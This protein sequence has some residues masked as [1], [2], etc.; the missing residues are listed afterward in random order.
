MNDY[1]EKLF[2]LEGKVAIVTGASRGIG[3]EIAHGLSS[4]GATVVGVA[5]SSQPQRKL[6][7][8]NYCQCDILDAEGF[9][10]ICKDTN[11]KFGKINILVNS[12]GISLPMTEKKNRGKLFN[13]ILDTNLSSIYR[14][15]DTTAEFMEL[16]GGG[17]IINIT[18]IGSYFGFPKNP[19]YV[20]SKGGVRALTKALA[21]DYVSNNIRV[22]NIV[23]GYVRT[24]MTEKSY[25][26]DKLNRE[27]VDRMMIPRWGKPQD[28][29]GASIY[30]SSDAS[31]YVTGT[32]LIVD[33]GWAAK[34]L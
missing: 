24:A 5:R 7:K 19:G 16:S 33:G 21:L 12:A 3:A 8:G 20:A 30:L 2:S 32:D 10:K 15:C 28:F 14:C 22:N 17:S 34:G 26:D 23:P 9:E 4:A 29:I 27:R 31:S 1:L 13:Q 18:S 6:P 25:L 11:H